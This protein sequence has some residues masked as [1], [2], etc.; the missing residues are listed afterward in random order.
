MDQIATSASNPYPESD[1]ATR[2]AWDVVNGRV[3]SGHL[4]IR[5]CRRHLDDIEGG[6]KRGLYWRPDLAK[7]ALDFFPAVLRVTHGAMEG[8]PFELPSYTAFVVGSLFGWVRGDGRLRFREAWIEAA[9]GGVKSPLAAAIG[10]YTLAFRGIARSECYAIAKDRNQAN[11]LFQDAVAMASAPIGD[12]DD[13]ASLVSTG[14]LLPRGTGDMTWMLEHPA[15]GSKFRALAGDEKVSGP[16]PSFVA[17]DEIHEWRNDGP[18]RMWR[19]SGVKMPGDFLL[20][21]TTNTPAADQLVGT[22]YSAR[23]QRILRGEI[24]DDAAFAFIARVDET[25]D[26]LVDETCWLKAMPCL[27][28]TFPIENVRIEVNSARNSVGTMLN[29]KR[30]YFGIP[31]GASEYWIDLDAWEAVQGRVD[32]DE[33]RG[34]PCWLGMDLSQKND[35]TALGAVWRD[36]G[37]KHYATCRYWKPAEGLADKA[38]EDN[39]PYVEWSLQGLLNTTPG[40]SIDYDFVAVEVQKF[41]AEQEVEAMAFD[42]AHIGEFRKACDRVGFDT[43]IWNPEE[44]AGAGLKMVVH[45]QGKRGM[46][47]KKALWMPRSLGQFEDLILT[48]QIVIDESPVT[49]WCAGNAAVQADEFGNRYFIKKNSRGR[50]DGMDALAMAVGA[51]LSDMSGKDNTYRGL[52][53]VRETKEQA[54]EDDDKWSPDIVSDVTHPLF[55]AHKARFERWELRHGEDERY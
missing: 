32:E 31:V 34:K 45:S 26:P 2:Y 40:K 3:V 53:S 24:D 51:A 37:G 9:K 19:S 41:C 46:E 11:V 5:A 25:D 42:P 54:I 10:I 20:F 8:R 44:S 21:M 52:Y 17:A 14:V 36:E 55:A 43:W 48:E 1:P 33:M 30:L 35:L 47:S 22:D 7:H 27:G 6:P 50:K 4:A 38:R 12:R 29:T 18:L 16:R 15:S 28:L 39:A 23:Y 49:S 13:D